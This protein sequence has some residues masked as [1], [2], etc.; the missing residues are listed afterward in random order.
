MNRYRLTFAVTALLC[1]AVAQPPAAPKYSIQAIHYGTM[2]S[3]D[4]STDPLAGVSFIMWLIR[5][6]GRICLLDAGFYAPELLSHYKI[7][8][9]ISPA[10]A[11]RLAGVEPDQITDIIVSHAHL[12]HIGGLD[13]FPKAVIWM[14]QAEYAYYTGPAWQQKGKTEGNHAPDLVTLV[15]LNT[16]G[17][18]RFINGDDREVLPGIRVYTGGRHTFS[19]Q[20]IRVEANP[21]AVL[22][23]DD[24]P[25]Y[26]YLDQ[27]KATS[28]F[29]PGDEEANRKALD[30]MVSLARGADRVVPGHDPLV[31][32][33]FPTTGRVATIR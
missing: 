26:R 20:Y 10:E 13:L 18:V 32:K 17:R 14:Q 4:A 25:F 28:T 33:R 11:V 29:E 16:E 21:P 5:G 3:P 31:F 30:R 22:A 1:A 9:F 24:C 27:R 8:D 6:Q 19:S 2:M 23:A 15:R 12:D 7:V